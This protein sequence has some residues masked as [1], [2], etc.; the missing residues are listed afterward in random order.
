MT[1]LR[2]NFLYRG[3]NPEKFRFLSIVLVMSLPTSGTSGESAHARKRVDTPGPRPYGKRKQ[4]TTKRTTLPHCLHYDLVRIYW[5]L[6]TRLKFHGRV[7]AY[8]VEWDI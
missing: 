8:L 1:R 4:Q 3:K 6:K 7:D 2:G 5:P